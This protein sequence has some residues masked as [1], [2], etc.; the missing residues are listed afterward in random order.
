MATTVIGKATAS[1]FQMVFPVIP[2]LDTIDEEEQFRLNIFGSVMPGIAITPL[3]MPWQGGVVYQEGGGFNYGDWSTSFHVDKNWTNYLIIYDWIKAANDGV[4]IFAAYPDDYQVTAHLLVFDNWDNIAVTWQ[5]EKVWPSALSD[6]E[7]S[8]R[9]GQE[10]LTCT[11]TFEYDFFK[12][13]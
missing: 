8:Y 5:F 9:D 10:I 6:V 11:V 3:E 13:L 12:K 2:G 7:I 1:H 4:S